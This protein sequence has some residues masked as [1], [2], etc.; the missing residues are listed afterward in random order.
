MMYTNMKTEVLKHVQTQP[1]KFISFLDAK[2]NKIENQI[3]QQEKQKEKQ[4][5]EEVGEEEYQEGGEE[6]EGN[7]ED[8]EEE[9]E[10][11]QEGEGRGEEEGEEEEMTEEEILELA[12]SGISP[13]DDSVDFIAIPLNDAILPQTP[14]FGDEKLFNKYVV[15]LFVS[16]LF[17]CGYCWLVLVSY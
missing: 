14:T 15:C 8:Y 10:G 4:L 11:G 1:Q 9:E 17:C 12:E 16:L 6:E 7:E 3:V 5:Q 13:F 2:K